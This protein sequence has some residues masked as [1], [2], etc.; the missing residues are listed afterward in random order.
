MS[1]HTLHRQKLDTRGPLV[2]VSQEVIDGNHHTLQS[3]L[4]PLSDDI[5]LGLQMLRELLAFLSV[6]LYTWQ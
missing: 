5:V 1:W 3:Q 2:H 4:D 6:W